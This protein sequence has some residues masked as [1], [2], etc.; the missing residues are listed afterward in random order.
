MK[1]LALA[2]T[3]L[4]MPA[5]ATGSVEGIATFLVATSIDTR[6]DSL[7][8][9][10]DAAKGQDPRYVDLRASGI[11]V[12]ELDTA[13]QKTVAQLEKKHGVS[14]RGANASPCKVGEAEIKSGTAIGQL[15]KRK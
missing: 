13:I 15:L 14:L 6:C 9:N 5:M 7:E 8:L 11:T 4:P 1:R 12:V 10:P 2:L 3:V